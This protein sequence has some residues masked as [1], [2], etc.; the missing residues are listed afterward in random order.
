MAYLQ[1]SDSFSVKV[2]DIDTQHKILVDMINTLHDALISHKG[3]D[4]QKEIVTR[5]V[6]YANTH[7]ELEENYMQ[8]F[9]YTG[10][11]EHKIEHAQFATKALELKERLE[12]AGFILTLE[13]LNY[14]K[15]WLQNHIL[16]TDKKYSNNFNENG[17][18]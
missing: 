6:K 10:Y 9:H 17:L 15:D 13:I 11:Q 16:G 1:W 2:R 5:M 14:L 12:K 4:A 3:P 7:F 18:F 8:Q